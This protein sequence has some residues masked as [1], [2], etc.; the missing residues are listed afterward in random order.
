[1]KDDSFKKDL[2]KEKLKRMST[3]C[4]A[5]PILP[6]RVLPDIT[7]VLV[8]HYCTALCDKASRRTTIFICF[9]FIVSF[10]LFYAIK[11]TFLS[12]YYSYTTMTVL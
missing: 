8:T 11:S 7:V 6:G 2:S 4:S 10:I 1:M 12:I 3:T 5:Y 9:V